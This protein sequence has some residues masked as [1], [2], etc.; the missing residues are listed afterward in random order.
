LLVDEL[1]KTIGLFM[2]R[3][4]YPLQ[5]LQLHITI[6]ELNKIALSWSF[7]ESS[8]AELKLLST[9]A[10]LSKRVPTPLTPPAEIIEINIHLYV[11]P[12]VRLRLPI[13]SLHK[14]ELD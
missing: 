7:P 3:E 2:I 5:I 8:A 12:R 14:T 11:H 9:S 6:Q 1:D 4:P 10:S 13:K